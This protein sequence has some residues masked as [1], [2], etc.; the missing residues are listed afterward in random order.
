MIE[1]DIIDD[2]TCRLGGTAFRAESSALLLTQLQLNLRRGIPEA[3]WEQVGRRCRVP[4]ALNLLG[5]AVTARSSHFYS[6]VDCHLT[7]SARVTGYTASVLPR[8]ASTGQV[9]R[10]AQVRFRLRAFHCPLMNPRAIGLR[11]LQGEP[12]GRHFSRYWMLAQLSRAKTGGLSRLP[13]T[14]SRS[15]AYGCGARH[16]RPEPRATSDRSTECIVTRP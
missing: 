15:G 7:W 8:W 10:R 13:T 6:G 9:R 5:L 12:L 1:V 3:L 2:S 4:R 14:R 16:F 11:D